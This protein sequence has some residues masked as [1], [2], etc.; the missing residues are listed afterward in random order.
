MQQGTVM[1][2]DETFAK[3]WKSLKQ[4]FLRL[5]AEKFRYPYIETKELSANHLKQAQ[6]KNSPHSLRQT[7]Q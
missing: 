5:Y 1:K 6:T 4:T 7:M 2:K 3:F